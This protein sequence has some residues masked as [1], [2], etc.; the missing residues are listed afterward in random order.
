M[1]GLT[2]ASTEV[3]ILMLLQYKASSL[4]VRARSKESS[5]LGVFAASLGFDATL[6]VPEK[7][8]E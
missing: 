8:T 3:E 7:P 5:S 2:L 1:K 6:D 4:S